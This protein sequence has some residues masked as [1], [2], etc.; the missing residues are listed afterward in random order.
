MQTAKRIREEI[1]IFKRDMKDN[2]TTENDKLIYEGW[3][4]ALEWV[5]SKRE[6]E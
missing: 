2:A 6:V 4:E 3:I 1:G 5:L